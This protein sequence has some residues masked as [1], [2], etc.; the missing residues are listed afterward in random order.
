MST[1]T[2]HLRQ[3]EDAPACAVCGTN[4]HRGHSAW[5]LRNTWTSERSD[6]HAGESNFPGEWLQPCGVVPAAGKGRG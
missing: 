6:Y 5:W 3:P 1:V 4:L 2:L